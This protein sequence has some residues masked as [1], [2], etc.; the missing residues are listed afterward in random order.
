MKIVLIATIGPDYKFLD[1]F[2]KYYR[3]LGV[4]E[5]YITHHQPYPK[6]CY[7][8]VCTI[9][10]ICKRYNVTGNGCWHGHFSENKKIEIENSLKDKYCDDKDWV[11]YADSDEFHYFDPPLRTQINYCNE[12]FMEAIEGRMLDRVCTTGDLMVY[13][14]GDSIEEIFVLGGYITR[15]LL[16]A[17]DKKIMVAKAARDIG[18]GHHVLFR[19]DGEKVNGYRTETYYPETDS[20]FLQNQ[21]HHFKWEIDLLHKLKYRVVPTCESLKA[22]AAESK[23]FLAYYE[24]YGRIIVENPV[25]GF[26]AQLPLL[27]V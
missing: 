3:D 5:I 9:S 12:H 1:K 24:K 13:H 22:W 17:W 15:Y 27:G 2:F 14:E 21:I 26:N 8:T 23:R 11:I 6:L 7:E 19:K 4:D 18:G 25:Y 10:D 20:F 16:G